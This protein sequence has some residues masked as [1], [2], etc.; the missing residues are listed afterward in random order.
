MVL[1]I[2]KFKKILNLFRKKLSC[3]QV[4]REE[5]ERV[6]FE[7]YKVEEFFMRYEVW[8]VFLRDCEVE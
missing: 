8:G 2:G 1:L 3:V 7:G 4:L 6:F 5:V